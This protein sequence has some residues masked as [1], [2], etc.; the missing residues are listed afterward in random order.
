M[1]VVLA[2]DNLAHDCRNRQTKT[3]FRERGEKL[4][5]IDLEVAVS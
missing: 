2:A 1:Q 5:R 3:R 4:K